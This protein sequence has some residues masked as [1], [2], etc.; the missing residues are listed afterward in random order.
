[1][2]M[3]RQFSNRHLGAASVALL[4][5]A[6]TTQPTFQAKTAERGTQT[7]AA[8]TVDAAAAGSDREDERN[9]KVTRLAG[10]RPD[11]NPVFDPADT[12]PSTIKATPDEIANLVNG[13]EV[14]GEVALTPQTVPAFI[15]TVFGAVLNVPYS[16]GP[17]VAEKTQI[18]S[19]R[20][21]MQMSKAA[22]FSQVQTAL[23]DY[24]LVTTIENGSV[25]ILESSALAA[26]APIFIR[27]R[28][29]ASVP[30]TSRPVIQFFELQSVAANSIID[31]LKDAYPDEN[32]VKFTPDQGTNTLVIA[33][34][35]DD[36]AEAARIVERMD[37][38]RLAGARV[39]RIEPVF[40]GADDLSRTLVQILNTEGYQAIEAA[41]S[42]QRAVNILSV[43]SINQLIIF[44]TQQDAYVRALY[45]VNELDQPSALGDDRAVFIYTARNTDATTLGELISRL[46]IGQGEDGAGVGVSVTP[47]APQGQG[48]QLG[49]NGQ[50]G[51]NFGG[52][53][54]DPG[55]AS[56]GRITIDV[57]GNR[58]LF[59]GTPSEF[60]RAEQLMRQLDTPPPQVLIEVTVAEVTLTDEA[61]FGIDFQINQAI[62]NGTAI[63]G[64]AQGLTLGGSGFNFSFEGD[65]VGVGL[66]ASASN[67]KI[68]VL[69]TPRL[70]AR[71]GGSASI[72]VGT[73]VPVITSQ[74]ATNVN[75]G[76]NAAT[77]VLQSVSYRQTGILLNIEPIVYG[78]DRIDVTISQE[79]SST[80]DDAFPGISSPTI[81][82]RNLQTEISLRQGQ[83]AVLGGLMQDNLEY[84]VNGIPF[85]KDIPG[86]GNLFKT[87]ST[88]NTKTELV[89]FI[90]PYVIKTDAQAQR[91]TSHFLDSI[92]AALRISRGSSYTLNP[93]GNYLGD[94]NVIE[95]GGSLN[96]Q[97]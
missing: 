7:E 80:T 26:G 86:V 44:A 54:N 51:G 22:F 29:H 21:S 18:V 9:T 48:A 87:N 53:Q 96:K 6:C 78:D 33:G 17:G 56:N 90:T 67:Q 88:N 42:V 11:A 50:T 45:W 58:I 89:V 3:R 72:Q 24:G 27:A 64:T 20:G 19:L 23:E 82:N 14:D 85:L 75:Q 79:V 25:R 92:N 8:P 15:D 2:T 70:V 61:D 12:A 94:E 65:D 39:A 30:E 93:F 16:M 74:R 32:A 57:A 59:Y 36:V 52:G 49:P 60:Q 40:W 31:V 69:S 34:N 35:A 68:N 10:P 62:Q 4:I 77:D 76:N 1:M 81:S 55:I 63:L 41:R 28:A 84:N 73:D 66:N 95:H 5:G 46:P 97:P 43:P 71:S 47:G 37:V 38:P 91:A 13:E 83:T